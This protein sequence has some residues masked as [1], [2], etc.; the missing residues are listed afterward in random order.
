[1]LPL[2]FKILFS[3]PPPSL[4]NWETGVGMDIALLVYQPHRLWKV[5]SQGWDFIF[6][7]FLFFYLT[8]LRKKNKI[9][10]NKRHQTLFFSF[11]FKSGLQR[12][13]RQRETI[14]CQLPWNSRRD[15]AKQQW[16]RVT[17]KNVN[18]PSHPSGCLIG[19]QRLLLTL[20][21]RK[22][23]FFFYMRSVFPRVLWHLL[24]PTFLFQVRQQP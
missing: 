19:S 4:T 6:F 12:R 5:Y 7:I 14:G 17:D 8:S 24:Q 11:F 3:C 2:F 15:S 20:Q 18:S 1:M 22:A 13:S 21:S 9:K 23:V 16:C 10:I